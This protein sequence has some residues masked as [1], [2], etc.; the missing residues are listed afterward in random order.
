MLFTS[1]T[2]YQ[3][4]GFSILS[5]FQLPIPS[6]LPVLW[7]PFRRRH[8]PLNRGMVN[9]LNSILRDRQPCQSFVFPD[10]V[11]PA[12]SSVVPAVPRDRYSR[13][14]FGTTSPTSHLWFLSCKSF[15]ILFQL[16]M[17]VIWNP[18]SLQS[19]QETVR[20]FRSWQT[21]ISFGRG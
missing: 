20:L 16:V 6:I 11:S 3:F 15:R 8:D 17:S 9:P 18:Q 7:D 13:Q 19:F 10:H 4:T 2:L 14:C 21:S 5:V 12:R 1:F